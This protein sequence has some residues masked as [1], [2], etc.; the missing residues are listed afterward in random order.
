LINRFPGKLK[1][2]K[3]SVNLLNQLW[4]KDWSP[5]LLIKL[6][7]TGNRITLKPETIYEELEYFSQNLIKIPELVEKLEGDKQI[8][9]R[10]LNYL[11]AS[12]I[13]SK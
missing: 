11:N 5:D 4:P 3:E 6:A 8:I 10:A 1:R 9:N 2:L 7:Q 13:F 12:N